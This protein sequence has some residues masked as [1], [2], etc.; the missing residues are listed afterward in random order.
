MNKRPRIHAQASG[1]ATSPPSASSEVLDFGNSP[2]RT[3][4]DLLV[5]DSP[6]QNNVNVMGNPPSSST[7]R[8]RFWNVDDS[9]VAPPSPVQS[10]ENAIVNPPSPASNRERFRA[11]LMP[12]QITCDLSS[13]VVDPGHRFTFQGIVL[14]VFPASSNPLRR[15]V[16]VG[17][18]RGAVGITVWNAHVNTFSSLSIGQLV[19][20]TKVSVVLHNGTR[21]IT[22][23]KDSTVSFNTLSDH[24]ASL[25]W[26]TIPQQS[27]VS[28]ILFCDQKDNTV[29]NVAGICGSVSVEQKTVRS[30]ARD[31]VTIK[32]VDR[33]G[34]ITLRTWNHCSDSFLP[35]V[36][37]PVMFRRIRVTSFGSF[38]TGE[39][40]DGSGTIIDTGN[41]PGA[42]DLKKFWSE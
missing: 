39:L 32:I 20:V 29:V 10:R 42:E 25:W 7:N 18:G 36:D 15:H 34:I 1:G 5:P 12:A 19:V 11:S 30:D 40:F 13:V 31:L 2:S 35:L 6:V 22:L 37:N 14:V 38:K 33:T 9:P 4:V 23:N 21:G 41:F 8:A 17:D 24:F 16:L 3:G 28:A 27:A 26:Q